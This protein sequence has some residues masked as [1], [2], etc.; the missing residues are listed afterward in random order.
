MMKPDPGFPCAKDT[1][2]ASHVEQPEGDRNQ[3]I[4]QMAGGTAVGN[5]QGAVFT[6]PEARHQPHWSR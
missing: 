1:D 3:A 6:A 2:E 4:G 5:A